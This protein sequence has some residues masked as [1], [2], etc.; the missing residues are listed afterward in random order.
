MCEWQSRE[1]E[2]WRE[3]LPASH[4]VIRQQVV[5]NNCSSRDASAAAS[6]ALHSHHHQ[7]DGVRQF[8]QVIAVLCWL[9]GLP[10][11]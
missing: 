9:V 1:G 10:G 5:V 7:L 8:R 11:Q 2:M 6:S 4:D 3:V